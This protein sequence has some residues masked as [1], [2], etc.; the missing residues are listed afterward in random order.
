MARWVLVH[1]QAWALVQE[2]AQNPVPSPCYGTKEQMQNT[3][4]EHKKN[5]R[6]SKPAGTTTPGS[7]KKPLFGVKNNIKKYP[8]TN[9]NI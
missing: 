5:T 9:I 4:L 1:A 3:L 6:K 8:Q 2:E 7:T